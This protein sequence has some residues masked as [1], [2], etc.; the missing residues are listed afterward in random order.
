MDAQPGRILYLQSFLCSQI[1][2]ECILSGA[3][4]KYKKKA[5][6]PGQATTVSAAIVIFGA[7]KCVVIIQSFR[8]LLPIPLYKSI[9]PALCHNLQKRQSTAQ[10]IT[11]APIVMA[12]FFDLASV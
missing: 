4:P 8:P 7:L 3:Q 2:W 1:K 11:S 6:E 9:I 12:S 10:K 5:Y